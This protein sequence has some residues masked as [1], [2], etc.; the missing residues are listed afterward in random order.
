MLKLI[1]GIGW[2]Q[3]M[4][5]IL[6]LRYIG[7]LK[8]DNDFAPFWTAANWKVLRRLRVK[9]RYTS[10]CGLL[11]MGELCAMRPDWDIIILSAQC[12]SCH[13]DETVIHFLRDCNCAQ[14]L[15]LV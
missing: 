6:F 10:L 11:Y 13:H 4:V 3:T 12:P 15:I 2:T 8:F 9:N 1:I 14:V 5:T 7:L